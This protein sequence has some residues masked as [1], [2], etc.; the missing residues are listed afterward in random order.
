MKGSKNLHVERSIK[1]I[2][3]SENKIIVKDCQEDIEHKMSENINRKFRSVQKQS[4]QN[5]NIIYLYQYYYSSSITPLILPKLFVTYTNKNISI[6]MQARNIFAVC[7]Y[8]VT[9]SFTVNLHSEVVWMSR[10]FRYGNRHDICR[11]HDCNGTRTHS[12]L[13]CKRTL[14]YLAKLANL[15][16]WLSACSQTKKMSVQ[17]PLQSEIYY[18]HYSVGNLLCKKLIM[19]NSTSRW[20]FLS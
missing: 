11:L 3:E 8:H 10:N 4:Q 19:K 13:V 18:Y 6:I 5:K 7:F 17:V 14:N 9:Y 2:E 16:K 15:V 1:K 12:H 20:K